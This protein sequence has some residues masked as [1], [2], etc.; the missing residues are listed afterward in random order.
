MTSVTLDL[1][2]FIAAATW[3][4][5]PPET[6]E[7]AKGLLLKTITGMV[8]GCR[9]PLGRKITD[10]LARTRGAP[11]AGIVGAGYRA[12]VENAA[13]A[14]G[15]FAHASELEDDQFPSG[16]GD[17]WVFPAI[18]SL[19]EKLVSSGR[20]VL[21]AAI[22]SWEVCS[23]LA[24]ALPGAEFPAAGIDTSN[25]LGPIATA[26]AA[27]RLLRLPVEQ[28][29]NALSIAAS[30]ASGFMGQLGSDAHFIQTG[31][32]QWA[33]VLSA[34]LAKEGCTGQP[35]ILHTGAGPYGP[36]WHTGKVDVT[37]IA[38]G[39]GESPFAVHKMWV[40]KFPC[41]LAFHIHI[42]ALM[43]IMNQHQL[44]NEDIELVEVEFDF[45]SAPYVD[46]PA[47]TLEAARFSVQ[48]GLAE[49]LL[50]GT[51]DL[52]SYT[53]VEKLKDPA[54]VLARSKVK[55][56]AREDWPVMMDH[57]GQVTVVTN[58][59]QRITQYLK[60]ALGGPDHP[61]TIVEIADVSRPYLD[62][63][64]PE[65]VSR[66]VEAILL[67]LEEQPDVRELMNLLTFFQN[68]GR[69]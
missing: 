25:W 69:H 12:S 28:T 46:R 16:I 30:H 56:I 27:A 29:Q 44:T 3:S 51:V 1:A 7:T 64:L 15:I 43:M 52:E 61:L 49:V 67:N 60:T 65:T 4:D 21:E 13:W 23:R 36:V 32:I 58:D 6:V 39:L 2:Q 40:K 41:C 17:Y 62:A 68:M 19:G 45:M 47:D 57:G 55:V 66:R 11:E 26:A 18:F 9:E 50:R 59:G 24:E 33:G 14:H 35:D 37:S 54:S 48:Y 22:V 42:D 10:H 31:A 53:R 38:N 8:A 20:D 63:F 34:F 5:F